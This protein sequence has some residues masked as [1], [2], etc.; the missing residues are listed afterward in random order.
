VAAVAFATD[1]PPNSPERREK[2]ATWT[3]RLGRWWPR[4]QTGRSCYVGPGDVDF[5]GLGPTVLVYQ[6]HSHPREIDTGLV[7]LSGPAGVRRDRP[8]MQR[9]EAVGLIRVDAH[10]LHGKRATVRVQPDM[11]HRVR[12]DMSFVCTS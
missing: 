1:L 5:Q 3:G 2:P 8:P 12:P 11:Q 9:P 6:L 10:E 4:A 7:E